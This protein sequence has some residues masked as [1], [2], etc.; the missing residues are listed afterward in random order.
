[1]AENGAKLLFERR[2]QL[3]ERF[4]ARAVRRKAWAALAGRDAVHAA[5]DMLISTHHC[6]EMVEGPSP[7]GGRPSRSYLWNPALVQRGR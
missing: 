6:R 4:T 3:P 7:Q 1:M 2:H 5:I